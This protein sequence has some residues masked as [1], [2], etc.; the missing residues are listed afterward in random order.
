MQRKPMIFDCDPGNDDAVALILAIRS[1]KYDILGI[2]VTHGNKP[3]ETTADNALRLVEFLHAD[4]PVYAGCP[5][6]MVCDLMPGRAQNVRAQHLHC[7]VDG[8]EITIHEEHLKLPEPKQKVQKQHACTFIVETL[9]AATMPVTVV[10]TAPLTNVAMALRMAPDICAKIERIVLMGGCV[11]GGNRTPAAEANFYHDPEAAQI[12]L[13]SGC[14]VQVYPLEATGSAMVTYEDAE[15][16]RGLSELGDWMADMIK[17]YIRRTN[18]LKTAPEGMT[19]VHDAVAVAGL[20]DPSMLEQV[21]RV[22]C[23][24]DCSGGWCD[25]KLVVD[26][27]LS[28]KPTLP[29]D[30]VYR[31][32]HDKF[33]EQLRRAVQI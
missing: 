4:I 1:G 26:E 17:D 15:S 12:V 6:P 21:R 18:L 16:L 19:P 9:R 22:Q 3:L 20:L 29:V 10:A 23:D 30:V 7:I 27:R 31:V 8:E 2:T 14:P 25:G 24:V 13:H 32:D 28:A 33:I 5:A 11:Y